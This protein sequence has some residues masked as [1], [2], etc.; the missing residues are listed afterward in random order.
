MVRFIRCLNP[1]RCAFFICAVT[2]FAQPALQLKTRVYSPPPLPEA[3]LSQ[4]TSKPSGLPSASRAAEGYG[5][6]HLGRTHLI[7][8]FDQAPGSATIAELKARGAAVL[9]HLPVNALILAAGDGLDLDNLGVRWAGELEAPDKISPQLS[10]STPD[11]IVEFHPDVDLGYARALIL[12]L[13]ILSSLDLRLLE[14]PDLAANHLMVHVNGDPLSAARSLAQRD[15]V[16]YIFPAAPE[17]VSGTAVQACAG[18]IV[19]L[20]EGDQLAFA[21][22]IATNGNGWDGPG[23]SATTLSYNLGQA[24]THMASGTSAS[25]V[26]RAMTEWSK[27]I[28]L[29]WQAGSS[30]TANRTVNIQFGKLNHG[31]PYPFDGPG[32]VLAHAFYPAPPNPE[33]LAGDLHFDDDENWH[34]G[35]NIDLFSVALH[36]LGHTLGLGHSD[37]PSDVMYPYYRMASTLAAGDKTAIL[38]MY[39]A[40][41]SSGGSPAPF[42]LTVN[43]PS[44][45]TT[46][47]SLSL[48]GSYTGG[49]GTA[50]VHW[51]SSAGGSGKAQ[52]SGTNWSIANIALSSGNN[53]I[54]ITA[55]DASGNATQSVT[56]V[57]QATGRDSTPPALNVTAPLG[58]SVLTSLSSINFSGTAKDNV[59]VS[60]VTWSSSTGPSGTAKGT[61][62]WTATVPLITGANQIT[63]R[64]YDAAGN[65]SW[66]TV[67]VTKR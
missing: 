59:G 26:Q 5:Q 65:S 28:K 58:T 55:S 31:D 33:P 49:T 47:A 2:V 19:T 13:K 10:A 1:I 45:P 51:S 43:T 44:S 54:T 29:T 15:E 64:A 17:L 27:V 36:E 50:T 9:G 4:L 7:V 37:S 67:L 48:S 41:D 24:S 20:S 56:V 14:N 63:V 16:S 66:T 30:A 60:N 3:S 52:V 35:T 6:T 18:P 46:A 11:W 8:Q 38:G 42:S 25:E 12:N 32:N 62:S 61:T 57:R 21:Q 53:T 39:A 23:K 34:V 22:L 40:Q